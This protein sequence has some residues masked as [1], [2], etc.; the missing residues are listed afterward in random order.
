VLLHAGNAAFPAEAWLG[1]AF[2]LTAALVWALYSVLAARL[3][4]VPSEAV[5]GFCAASGVIAGIAHLGLESS[6]FPDARQWAVV[7]LL[8]LGPTGAAFFLWD[9][10]MKRGDP[11]LLGTLAYAVPVA[12]TLLL[13]AMGE[14]ALSARM[15]LAAALVSGGG[16]LAALAG[17]QAA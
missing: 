8:G 9:H 17:R 4:S 7:A 3:G 16:L 14:G 11:R 6:A 13:V 5:A 10:G 2:A 1:F 12:S 15:L